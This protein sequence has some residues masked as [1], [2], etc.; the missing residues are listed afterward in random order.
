MESQPHY[1]KILLDGFEVEEVE[2]GE[3]Y[4]TPLIK[5]IVEQAGKKIDTIVP[6]PEHCPNIVLISTELE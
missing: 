3:D 2:L 6:I 5:E 4:I 1:V